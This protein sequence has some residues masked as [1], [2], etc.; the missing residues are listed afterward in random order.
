MN[1]LTFRSGAHHPLG[2]VFY[3]HRNRSSSVNV[4]PEAYVPFSGSPESVVGNEVNQLVPYDVDVAFPSSRIPDWA[5]RYQV[6]YP[7]NSVYE[8]SLT[9]TVAEALVADMSR[10]VIR[11][12]SF[13]ATAEV[14]VDEFDD[15]TSTDADAE[16]TFPSMAVAEAQGIRNEGIYVSMRFFEG[17]TDSYKESKSA[18]L[19]YE[20][21]PGDKLRIVS[22]AQSG[23][24]DATTI[25]PANHF[26]DI[27]G[28][29]YFEPNS[30]RNVLQLPNGDSTNFTEE[31]EY[32]RSGWFLILRGEDANY[33]GFRTDDLRSSNSNVNKWY[34]DCRVEILRPKIQPID[35]EIVYYEIGE[36]YHVEKD[37]KD[38]VDYSEQVPVTFTGPDVIQTK[39]RLFI[40]DSITPAAFPS[41]NPGDAAYFGGQGPPFEAQSVFTDGGSRNQF[42]VERVI[43]RHYNEAGEFEYY[44]Y[45]VSPSTIYEGQIN[46]IGLLNNF[47]MDITVFGNTELEAVASQSAECIFQKNPFYHNVHLTNQG[48]TYFRQRTL[49]QSAVD[50]VN[51]FDP[52]QLDESTDS[53]Y[54]TRNV[55][56]PG[57]NDFLKTTV[58]QHYHY[59]R[60]HIYSAD[61]RTNLRFSSVTYSDVYASD[62][63]LLGLS[64]FNPS[65]Y[66]FKDYSLRNGSIQR[67]YDGGAKITVLQER[68][69]SI[70]PVSRDYIQTAEGGMLITSNNVLGAET[71]YQGD[72]GPGIHSRGIVE[73]DGR[74]YF[75]D[76]DAGVVVMV[77]GN[78]VNIISNRKAD[79]YFKDNFQALQ[80]AMVNMSVSLSVHPD[81]DE[82]IVSFQNR[83]RR[84]ISAGGTEFGR[85]LPVDL[86]SDSKFILEPL[87]EVHHIPAHRWILPM[88][89]K[90]GVTP[91]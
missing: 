58:T 57:F 45:R 43:G 35:E 60:P 67:M 42:R 52:G 25:Y 23:S 71:Y 55:E 6:V 47:V 88:K 7:G 14:S 34:Q 40:G 54:V 75:A 1:R 46:A 33:P 70:T 3:D 86:T 36:S 53:N 79:S 83:V 5:E 21:R 19:Q 72:H 68:K 20:Y 11:D 9:T 91:S 44:E 32:R 26:F 66:P 37:S 29:R 85:G 51:N 41:E 73:H 89:V 18:Q 62:G 38:D 48:D 4:L 77:G 50:G 59:G 10:V 74:I 28:Y 49:R 15:A 22:Y 30:E 39:Q 56:D 13:G 17:K 81:N 76:I 2:I 31:G 87:R 16:S 63:E 12:P 61:F 90:S 65:L 69:V 80:D 78:G 84:K 82:L 24:S 27:V 8:W 64:S